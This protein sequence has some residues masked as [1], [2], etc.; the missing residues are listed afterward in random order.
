MM[1]L[2]TTPGTCSLASHIALRESGL[3]FTAEIVNLRAKTLADGGDY[4]AINAKGAVPALEISPGD[5]L[6][7]GVAIMQYVADQVP[8]VGIAPPAGTLERARLQEALNYIAGELH[9]SGYAILFRPG[10]TDEAKQAQMAVIDSKLAWLEDLLADGREYLLPAG[11]SLADG[12]LFTI[13][14]WSAKFGHDLTRFPKITALR[15]R[16]AARPAVQAALRAE[17]M[18]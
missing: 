5:V 15:D 1:R 14:G 2:F 17:G 16:V 6:T 4:R 13:S 10:L 11:Y 8:N 9:K 12:Y 3:E 7:E 18:L